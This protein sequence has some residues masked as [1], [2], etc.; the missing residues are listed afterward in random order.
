MPACL[1]F[2][3]CQSLSSEPLDSHGFALWAARWP[4]VCAGKRVKDDRTGQEK[5]IKK[6]NEKDALRPAIELSD[7]LRNQVFSWCNV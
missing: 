1:S 7:A 2:L 4:S 5:E 3:V 6:K